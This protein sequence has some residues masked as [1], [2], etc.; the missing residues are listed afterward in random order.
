MLAAMVWVKPVLEISLNLSVSDAVAALDGRAQGAEGSGPGTFA[1]ALW[2]SVW[3]PGTCAPACSRAG[4]RAASAAASPARALP[5]PPGGAVLAAMV[6]VAPVLE[7]F[8]PRL[9]GLWSSMV[10][11]HVN[12]SDPRSIHDAAGH[13]Y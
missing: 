5:R 4:A 3:G 6:R 13:S 9:S 8:L 11:R 1:W 12:V 7:A 2:I 10:L